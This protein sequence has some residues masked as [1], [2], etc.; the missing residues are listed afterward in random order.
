MSKLFVDEI[1][2]QSSQGSGTITLGASGETVQLA[3]GAT[4]SGFGGTNTPNFYAETNASQSLTDSVYLTMLYG[5][6]KY[7]TAS[8]YDTSTG[9]FTVPSGQ[10]GKYFFCGAVAFD[11]NSTYTSSGNLSVA[12]LAHYNSSDVFQNACQA[13][14]NFNY[15][16]RPSLVVSAVF[17]M[18]V[19]DYVILQGFITATSSTY[20][21][22]QVGYFKGFK[23]VE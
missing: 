15:A 19:G 18:S 11:I 8:A 23:L 10:A 21:S 9:K 7:D 3:A 4:Q 16:N 12:R 22:T 2:H 1:V 20:N 13:R 6:E 17:D 5:T 14:Q